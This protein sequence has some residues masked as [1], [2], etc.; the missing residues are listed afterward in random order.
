M[1][2]LIALT[3]TTFVYT[4]TISELLRKIAALGLTAAIT[5]V[6]HNAR[7]QHN[8]AL[9]AFASQLGITLLFLPSYSPN[10]NLI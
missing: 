7:Y 8:A 2:H 3:N 5:L 6:L 10:L 1:R 9:K 4:E